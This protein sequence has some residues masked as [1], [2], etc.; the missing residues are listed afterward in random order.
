MSHNNDMVLY[1]IV[2]TCFYFKLDS[3][4]KVKLVKKKNE[5]HKA[6]LDLKSFFSEEI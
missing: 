5:I 2:F 1:F 4:I 3:K 6:T